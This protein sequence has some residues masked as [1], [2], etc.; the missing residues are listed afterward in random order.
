MS[1][2]EYEALRCALASA[3]MEGFKVTEWGLF[4][5]SEDFYSYRF[6][7][8]AAIAIVSLIILGLLINLL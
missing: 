1:E 3:R 8:T 7:A 5:N 2:R 4:E 6:W